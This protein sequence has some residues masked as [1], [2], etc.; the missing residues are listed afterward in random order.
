MK[1]TIGA[2]QA[3]LR[4]VQVTFKD[5]DFVHTRTVNAVTDID[6]SYDKAATKA[7]VDE[8]AQGVAAKRARGV[9]HVP[10]PAVSE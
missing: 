6:G 7:R 9:F 4:T 1:I 8:V 5:G 10:P 3:A 2:F